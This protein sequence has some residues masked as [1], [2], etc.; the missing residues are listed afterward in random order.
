M[1]FAVLGAPK[2]KKK[3]QEQVVQPFSPNTP[4]QTANQQPQPPHTVDATKLE[5]QRSVPLEAFRNEGEGKKAFAQRVQDAG[6]PQMFLA[7][8]QVTAQ[9]IQARQEQAKV[10]Q[11]VGRDVPIISGEAPSTGELVRGALP[12]IGI[13]AGSALAGAGLGAVVCGETVATGGIAVVAGSAILLAQSNRIISELKEEYQG[14]KT[15]EYVSFQGSSNA[16]KTIIQQVDSGALAPIDAVQLFNME[17][18][19][20]DKAERVLTGLEEKS[21]LGKNRKELIKITDFNRIHRENYIRELQSA[22]INPNPDRKVNLG[23]AD[24]FL[25]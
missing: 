3:T 1:A 25:G 21:W 15:N 22:I 17:L 6:G 5:T 8:Q 18:A 19:R 14:L 9:D 13:G 11:G 24:D 7:P 4:F 20:I 2:K 10:A 23:G 12:D 16:L